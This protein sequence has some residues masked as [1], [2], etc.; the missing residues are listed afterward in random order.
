MVSSA[1]NRPAWVPPR[2]RCIMLSPRWTKLLRD[3]TLTP[4]RVILMVLAMAAGVCA[5]ATMLSSYTILSRETTR[6]YLDTNPPS[7]TLQLDRID[8]ALLAAI[9]AFPGIAQAQASG[10]VGVTLAGSGDTAGLPLTI[11]VVDD[12]NALNINTVYREA[13]AWP[14]PTGTLLLEREALRLIGARVGQRL[15]VSTGHGAPQQLTIA[16]TLHDPALPPA[17]R[18]QTVYAYATPATVAALG[19]DG[20]LR[21]LKLT[22]S[23]QAMDVE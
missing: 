10:V 20:T 4:G 8:P 1:P 16:G 21:Q 2:A 18:G 9:R 14:P 22:V 13:G 3:I 17:N 12:F 23:E 5:L 6:N 15:S 7:A 11:F 19:L